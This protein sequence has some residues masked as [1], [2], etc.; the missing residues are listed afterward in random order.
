MQCLGAAVAI[1]APTVPSWN[2]G[3]ADGSVGG[4][5]GAM[6]SPAGGFGKFLTVLIAL[7]VTANVAPTLYSFCLSFQVFMP[8]LVVVPRYVFSIVATAMYVFHA[9][10]SFG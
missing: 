7:S 3:Y 4:L 5:I 1:A 8:F 10:A 6:V 9:P 2:A